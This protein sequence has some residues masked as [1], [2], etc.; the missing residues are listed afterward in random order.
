MK[1]CFILVLFFVLPFAFSWDI[2]SNIVFKA[3]DPKF[4]N[5][6]FETMKSYFLQN[7]NVQGQG[8]VVASPDTQ[9]PV[10]G[11]TY[12][13]DWQRDGAISMRAFMKINDYNLTA[14]TTNMESYIQWVIKVQ[15]QNDPNGFDIR[16]EPKYNLPNGDVFTGGWG[17]PQTDGPG[18]RAS[19]LIL[20]ALELLENG[21]DDYVLNYLWTK[22]SN[23][24]HGG[25][26]KYDLD[27]ISTSW[28]TTIS[29]DLWEDNQSSDIFWSKM[30][31]R[32]AMVYGAKLANI[33]GDTEIANLYEKVASDIS[34]LIQKHWNGNFY[35][36]SPN[37]EKDGA[38]VCAFNTGYADDDFLKPTDEKVAKTVSVLNSVFC[39]LYAINQ[40]DSQDN[41]PGV[42]YGRYVEDNYQNGNPWQLITAN[43]ANLFYR[44]AEY[45]YKKK[46]N[47]NQVV[48]DSEYLSWKSVL[49]LQTLSFLTATDRDLSLADSF[50]QAGDAVLQRI[51][52][53]VQGDNFHLAEQMDKNS[54]VQMSAKDLTWSYGELL[55]AYKNRK[56]AFEAKE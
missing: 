56:A 5:A 46:Q 54:G 3:S 43:L 6:N 24:Y 14:I 13:F 1:T 47:Q 29:F 22:D 33:M 16:I 34:V 27:W 2:C 35:I 36:Q 8:G 39:N 26:I 31:Q 30:N 55:V 50:I 23:K 48:S 10:G 37:R 15:N 52:H 41:V 32:Q 25:A 51:Y 19:T 42:L 12:F 11:G 18:L 9:T 44:A 20:Y 21:K 49:N 17:R 38:V 53:H 7:L 28:S 45:I 40:K 4:T